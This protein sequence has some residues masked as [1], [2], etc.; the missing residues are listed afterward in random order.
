[1]LQDVPETPCHCVNLGWI[2]VWRVT[3][4]A[5]PRKIP[6]P[7]T[8]LPFL[9]ED[10]TKLRLSGVLESGVRYATL[11]HC[12][13][14]H[15]F[16][17]LGRVDPDAFRIRVPAEVL[18]KTF[19][20]AIEIARFL[21]IDYLWI[22]SL[23]IL[24]DDPRDWKRASLS[25]TSVYGGSFVNLAASRPIDGSAGCFFNR[26]TDW[27]CQIKVRS[28]ESSETYDAIQYHYGNSLANA[29]LAP[30]GWAIQEL[31]LPC[32]TLLFT[33][34]EVFWECDKLVVSATF[35]NQDPPTTWI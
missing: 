24:Q 33:R 17:T 31:L 20:D 21:C 23:C 26:D 5:S 9:K 6:Q 2:N 27:R 35:P 30:Q 1:M 19:T 16:L 25:M 34:H 10:E 7:P 13:G 28:G 4:T 22:D 18:P 11:S 29:P 32:R 3:K 8:R 12:W 14:S 15:K